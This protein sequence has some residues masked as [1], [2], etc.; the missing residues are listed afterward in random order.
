MIM[1]AVLLV[2]KDKKQVT[3]VAVTGSVFIIGRSPQCDLPVDEPLASRQHAEIVMEKGVYWIRDRGSRNGTLVN[4]EKIGERR[5]LKD[6]DEIGIGEVRLKFLFDRNGGD[7]GDPDDEATRVASFAQ[8]GKKQPGQKVVGK[9]DKGSMQVKLR[10]VDG[11]LHGGV[12][13]DWVSP[14]SIGRGLENHVVLL[15]DAVS[16]AHALIVQEGEKYFIEDL[17]SANGTFLDGV[18]VQRTRLS[19]GQK[20]KIGTSTLAF[21][22]VDLRAKRRNLRIALI[23]GFSVIAIAALVKY[24]Q[25][26][27]LAGEHIRA[28]QRHEAQGDLAKAQDEF[29]FALRIDPGRPE[30][31]SGLAEVKLQIGAGILLGQAEKEAAA[32]NYDKAKELVYRV[33]RDSPDMA[34]AQE[35]EAVIKSIE[36]ARI[37]F[38]ARNWT[39]ARQ[40]LEKAQ[41]AYPKSEL[42]RTRLDQAQKEL[43]A[44][45]NLNQAKDDLQHGQLDLAEPLLQSIPANSAYFT[46]AK[47]QLDQIA[48]NRQIAQFLNKAQASYSDGRLDEALKGIDAGLQQE[49]DNAALLGLQQRVR[50]MEALVKPL[51]VAEAMGQPEDVDALLQDQKACNAVISLE[52]N[53]LNSLRKRAGNAAGRITAKLAELA[54]VDASK[55][56]AAFQAGNRREALLLYDLAVK[57]NSGDPGILGQRDKVYQQ[58]V[59]D[60]RQLYQKGIVHEDLGQA[61]MARDAY[62]QVLAIGIPGEDYYRKAANKLKAMNQ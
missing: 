45:Q 10:V 12:F 46:E 34:R 20:I 39:D 60:C 61:D 51:E 5:K 57:A 53:P 9:G 14:L 40:L 4:G 24:F 38:N 52:E 56:A 8:S 27:D 37:A 17:N 29:A 13:R 33:L 36:N 7:A 58:I 30:A 18:K 42:I 1:S 48:R 43:T 3:K 16:S 59:A 50:Q 62:R 26:P 44:E 32:E 19:N 54:Q 21:E 2:T 28:A 11:P 41:E 35:L 47:E 23:G 49:G 55:A 31:N 15:D 22:L 6:G 25:P